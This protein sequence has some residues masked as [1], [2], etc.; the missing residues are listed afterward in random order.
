MTDTC[1]ITLKKRKKAA[2]PLTP[3]SKKRKTKLTPSKTARLKTLL[4][5]PKNSKSGR[6]QVYTYGRRSG[7]PKSKEDVKH[8]LKAFHEY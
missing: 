1:Y 8:L 4:D 2:L 6:R 5:D 7:L 3:P